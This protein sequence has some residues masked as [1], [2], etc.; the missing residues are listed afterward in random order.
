MNIRRVRENLTRP[1]NVGARIQFE[2]QTDRMISEPFER[3]REWLAGAEA[4]GVSEPSA[5]ALGTADLEG[6]PSVRMML[7]KGLD[8]RGFVL[9]T[10]FGSRKAAQLRQNASAALCFFWPEVGR[11]VRVEGTVEL[12]S[13]E[14]A[15]AYFATRPRMSQIGAWASEQSKTLQSRQAFIERVEETE[16][17][18]AGRPIPRPPFWSGF[19]VVPHMMEFWTAREFRLHE[20][21]VYER[22]DEG[23]WSMRLVYP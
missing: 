19:R 3:F 13:G 18:Y 5:V 6:R 15:D 1:R 10:N 11:Q 22:A 17:H 23:D 21:E 2:A 8:D 4:G 9:Y 7:L 12:L 16:R 14:E 20:R